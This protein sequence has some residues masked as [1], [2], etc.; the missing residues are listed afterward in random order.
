VGKLYKKGKYRG[1]YCATHE[2][3]RREPNEKNNNQIE[4]CSSQ[5]EGDGDAKALL[6]VPFNTIFRIQ[7]I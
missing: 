5:P 1:K 3:R 2:V 4:K 7:K 6:L